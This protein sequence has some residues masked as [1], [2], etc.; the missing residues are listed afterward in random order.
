MSE[1]ASSGAA[2]V[3][4]TSASWALTG[5]ASVLHSVG[6]KGWGDV[7]AILACI[8]SLLVIWDWFNKRRKA[9]K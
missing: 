7:A 4:G 6:I 1:P 9:R 2:G 3:A 8:C 5:L